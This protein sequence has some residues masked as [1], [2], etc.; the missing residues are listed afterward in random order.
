MAKKLTKALRGK[1]RWIGCECEGF[2]SRS[3]V[4]QHIDSL[5]VRL[6]DFVAEKCILRV[7]LE[8]YDLVREALTTGPITS[9]TSSGKIALVR[10]RLR[11]S[12]PARKR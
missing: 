2:S 1:H 11:L 8:D 9:I 5:P 4:E 10:E 7:G 3:E 12:R 6:F